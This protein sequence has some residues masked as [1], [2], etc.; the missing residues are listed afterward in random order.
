M[1]FLAFGGRSFNMT[2]NI[3]SGNLVNLFSAYSASQNVG[4]IDV[5]HA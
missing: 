4:G 3:N 5:S 1:N 2:G